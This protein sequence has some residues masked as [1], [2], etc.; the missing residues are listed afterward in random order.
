MTN[1]EQ[2]IQPESPQPS[3]RR[4]WFFVKTNVQKVVRKKNDDYKYIGDTGS[5][6]QALRHPLYERTEETKG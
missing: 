2:V 4:A 1:T 5:R 6:K 3:T